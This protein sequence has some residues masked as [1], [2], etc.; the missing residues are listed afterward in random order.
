MEAATAYAFW[1]TKTQSRGNE[2]LVS[3]NMRNFCIYVERKHQRA[4]NDDEGATNDIVNIVSSR[5]RKR[6]SGN[7]DENYE[8]TD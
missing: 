1:K 3:V 2:N 8:H 7:H 5:K 4:P 6:S